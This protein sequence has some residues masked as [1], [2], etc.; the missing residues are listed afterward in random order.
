MGREVL[1]QNVY[2]LSLPSLKCA[3]ASRRM[4]EEM[5]GHVD[6]TSN[7]L[8]KAQRRMQGFIRENQSMFAPLPSSPTS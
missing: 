1:D 7:R 5:D 2:V 8:A 4:L 6:G 3:Y